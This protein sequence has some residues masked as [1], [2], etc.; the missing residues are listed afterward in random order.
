MVA[1]LGGF[2]NEPESWIFPSLLYFDSVFVLR[3]AICLLYY[4]QICGLRDD[5]IYDAL[6]LLALVLFLGLYE[7]L[8][9]SF[10]SKS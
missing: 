2:I 7:V 4:N 1:L 9:E 5:C 3:A 6:T 10:V 8:L